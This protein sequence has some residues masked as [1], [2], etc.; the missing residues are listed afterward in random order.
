MASGRS[1]I[2]EGYTF[3]ASDAVA[4]GGGFKNTDAQYLNS[5]LTQRGYYTVLA[6]GNYRFKATVGV[7]AGNTVTLQLR[8]NGTIVYNNTTITTNNTVISVDLALNENDTVA[9]W[10]KELIDSSSNFYNQTVRVADFVITD[11][12]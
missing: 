9:Y 3:S 11:L 12:Y 5:I 1:N 10:G 8:V 2:Q 7:S 4:A 6:N